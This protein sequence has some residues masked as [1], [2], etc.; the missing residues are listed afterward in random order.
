M[1]TVLYVL[2][3]HTVLCFFSHQNTC[4]SEVGVYYLTA[5][6]SF[7]SQVEAVLNSKTNAT[8]PQPF[9]AYIQK[10]LNTSARDN[11]VTN[12][13]V[14][15]SDGKVSTFNNVSAEPVVD[16]CT[17][18]FSHLDEGIIYVCLILKHLISSHLLSCRH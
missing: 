15:F 5:L 17:L 6:I 2:Y 12:E 14:L 7:P 18:L 10:E 8:P 9:L 13:V 1:T 4:L 16:I 3:F 11:G